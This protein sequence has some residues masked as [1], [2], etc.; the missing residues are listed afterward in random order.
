MTLSRSSRLA[1]AIAGLVHHTPP[2]HTFI[3]GNFDNLKGAIFLL[4]IIQTVYV[5][6]FDKVINGQCETPIHHR[7]TRLLRDKIAQIAP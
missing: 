7:K 1:G 2:I 5:Q 4:H 6:K 3:I